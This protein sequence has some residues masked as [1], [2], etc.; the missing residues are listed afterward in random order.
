MHSELKRVP[1]R[2]YD[3][4]GKLLLDVVLEGET[5]HGEE[6]HGPASARFDDIVLP[7]GDYLLTF[8]AH[9]FRGPGSTSIGDYFSPRSFAEDSPTPSGTFPSEPIAAKLD[10]L[11]R[12]PGKGVAVPFFRFAAD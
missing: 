4:D 11:I 8:Y 2:I 7:A 3:H 6:A 12:R 9:R 5:D 10:E 1:L